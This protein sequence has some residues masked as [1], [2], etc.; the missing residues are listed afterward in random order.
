MY[1]MAILFVCVLSQRQLHNFYSYYFVSAHNSD[2][3]LA[4]IKPL[5]ISSHNVHCCVTQDQ[6]VLRV[7]DI[8]WGKVTSDHCQSVAQ[9]CILQ[10]HGFPWW[11]GRIESILESQK[12]DDVI[13]TQTATVVW[14]ASNT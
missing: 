6:R 14:F 7:D 12:N 8:V 4:P 1:N 9:T 13:V 3:S 11:P 2:E 5:R 10:V